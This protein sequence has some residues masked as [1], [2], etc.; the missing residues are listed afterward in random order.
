MFGRSVSDPRVRSEIGVVFQE[1]VMDAL[2]TV[3]ENLEIRGGMYGLTKE[4]LGDAVD[5]AIAVTGC[6]DFSDRRYGELSGGQRRR[7]DIA[8]ALVHGPRLIILDEPTSGLD[9]QS[10]RRIWDTVIGLNR[11]EGLTVL[12]TTH[13]LEEAA[14]ADSMVIM[15]RGRIAASGTPSEIRERYSQDRLTIVPRDMGALESALDGMGVGHVRVRSGVEVLLSRT[16]DAI[17]ILAG[18]GEHISSFEVRMGTLD[19]AFLRITGGDGE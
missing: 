16:V 11:D 12:L 3:R 10:R 8:R 17:P 5:K 9:P 14:G 1:P 15:D 6:D 7:C 13:Y 19:D 4:A 18:A 2:L